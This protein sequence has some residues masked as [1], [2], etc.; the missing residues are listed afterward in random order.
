MARPVTEVP[1][2]KKFPEESVRML[3]ESAL[4]PLPEDRE[5]ESTRLVARI[6]DPSESNFMTK[7]PVRFVEG[8]RVA[9]MLPFAS[10]GLYE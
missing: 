10:V 9:K 1:H 5:S 6:P 2:T 4:T 7:E 8:E 3:T